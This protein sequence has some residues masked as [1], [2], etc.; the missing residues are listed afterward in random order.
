M[1]GSNRGQKRGERVNGGGWRLIVLRQPR[2]ASRS[3][4]SEA[5]PHGAS[6]Q[7][8]ATVEP[9]SVES[10]KPEETGGV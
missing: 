1:V 4:R 8:G 5:K 3:N 2:G 6:S 10:R 7:L 9:I